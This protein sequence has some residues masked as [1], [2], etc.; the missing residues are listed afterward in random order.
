MDEL[1]EDTRTLA[2]CIDDLDAARQTRLELQ[3]RVDALAETETYLRGKILADLKQHGLSG[4]AGTAVRV[5]VKESTVPST[6][7]YAALCK[8]IQETGQ[9]DLMQ[10]RLNDAAIRDRWGEGL[11]VPG[12]GRVVL[13]KLSINKI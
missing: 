10:R 8:Y 13:K 2:E 11:E 6:E 1:K 9:F 3:K 4:A 5:S 7:D 12:V